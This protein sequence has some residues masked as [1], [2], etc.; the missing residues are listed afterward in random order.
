MT[1]PTT[2]AAVGR[3]VAWAL[4]IGGVS[5]AV[6]FFGPMIVNPGANQGPLLGILITGPLGTVV[7]LVVGV[8]REA[9][10]RTAGPLAVLAGTRLRMAAGPDVL[11]V[12]AAFGGAVL[13]AYGL[14]GVSAGGGRGPA[15]AIVVGAASLGY[16]LTGRIPTW[17]RR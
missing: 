9:L 7:G 16:A 11:R 14:T 10:G 6:G 4:A 3:I 1:A 5:F 15:A 12:A 8:T 17:F 13:V 2:F